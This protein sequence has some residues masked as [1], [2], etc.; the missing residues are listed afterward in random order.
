MSTP[1]RL[2]RSDTR[3]NPQRRTLL[4]GFAAAALVP[5]AACAPTG[6]VLHDHRLVGRL[7]DVR[8]GRE[9][10]RAE[11][12]REMLAADVLLLG[13][14]HDNPAHHR[15]QLAV[16]KTIAER[17]SAVL[18]MEQFDSE[19]QAAIEAAQGNA[20]TTAESIADAGK[21]SRKGWGW[22]LYEPLVDEAVQRG[23]PVVGINLSRGGARKVAREG[24]GALPEGR[25]R[26]I[27]ESVWNPEREARLAKLIT[28]GH[29]NQISPRVLKMIVQAQRGRDAVMAAAIT[30]H[31]SR[32]VVTILGRGHARRDIAVPI[33]LRELA[34]EAKVLSVGMVEVDEAL[35]DAAAYGEV[36]AGAFD[37]VWFTPRFVRPDPCEAM[38]AAM[39]KKGMSKK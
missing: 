20:D 35:G 31:L 18:A 4:A 16:L 7:F 38:S 17:R 23:L 25:G 36:K 26:E 12:L 30:P 8:N 27:V 11:A 32:T 21:L 29:C 33:Y 2:T 28:I 14:T 24:F 5:L 13:E 9:I 34:P 37:L 39:L 22:P 1:C 15:I 3:C 19:H 10:S 6:L